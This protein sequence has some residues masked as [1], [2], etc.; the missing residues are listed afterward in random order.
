MSHVPTTRA[1][2]IIYSSS[3][4]EDQDMLTLQD[5]YLE[6]SLTAAERTLFDAH[7]Q[8]CFPC[9]IFAENSETVQAASEHFGVPIGDGLV[10]YLEVIPLVGPATPPRHPNWGRVAESMNESDA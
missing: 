4:C 7:R 3:T 2:S 10:P 5:R 6:G 9:A 1:F 8:K